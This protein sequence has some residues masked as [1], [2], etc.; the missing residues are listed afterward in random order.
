[1]IKRSSTNTIFYYY[2]LYYGKDVYFPPVIYI[3]ILN[4]KIYVTP[5]GFCRIKCT[6]AISSALMN[7]NC[8]YFNYLRKSESYIVLSH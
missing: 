5:E 3:C 6:L 8:K 4:E 1:M 7:A 2:L